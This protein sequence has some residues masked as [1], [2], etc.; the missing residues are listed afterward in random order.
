M[1][2]ITAIALLALGTM[3]SAPAFAQTHNVGNWG[4]GATG[5]NG[6]S[7]AFNANIGI[8]NNTIDAADTVWTA[9]TLTGAVSRDCSYYNA[10]SGSHTIP[11]GAIGVRT[12]ANEPV[13]Q[14]FNQVSD[15]SIE[16]TSTSA[17]CNFANTVSVTK[18]NGAD[19]LLNNAPGGYD[20]DNFTANIPYVARVGIQKATTSTTAPGVGTY[21]T[22]EAGVNEATKSQ[23]FGAFRSRLTLHTI[24]PAQP[25]GLVAG[26]YSD[27]VTVQLSVAS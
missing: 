1:K 25:L 5:G 19:G 12:S 20:T 17:G 3:A 24:V 21:K 9:F 15:F 18:A 2:K 23:S 27:T 22:F 10:N 13:G 6:A 16:M 4:P 8:P 14:M 7:L 11:L 26:T